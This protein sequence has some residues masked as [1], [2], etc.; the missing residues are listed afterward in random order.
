MSI[1]I[2]CIALFVVHFGKLSEQIDPDEINEY[3]PTNKK[4][5]KQ[6]VWWLSCIFRLTEKHINLQYVKE[7][8]SYFS[9][10]NR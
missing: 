6:L 8:F 3:L 9:S 1:Y 4:C 7:R 2:R 5:L 10:K